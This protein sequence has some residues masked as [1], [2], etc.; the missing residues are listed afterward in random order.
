VFWRHGYSATSIDA[1]R[2]VTEVE[3]EEWVRPGKRSFGGHNYVFRKVNSTF[4]REDAA[5]AQA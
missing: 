5:S 2:P 3:V 1:D 4:L